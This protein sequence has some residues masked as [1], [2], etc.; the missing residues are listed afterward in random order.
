VQLSG[1]GVSSYSQYYTLSTRSISVSA[2]A[3]AAVACVGSWGDWADCSAACGGGT[4]ARSYT[5]T[6]QDSNGG[7]ACPSDTPQS[8][9]CNADACA[10]DA[11]ACVG[12]WGD[13]ADCSA[14]CGGGTEARSYTVTRQDSNGGT[15]CPSDTPQSQSCNVAACQV[16]DIDCEITF[17]GDVG[18]IPPGSLARDTFEADFKNEM[19]STL[20]VEP[21]TI[22]VA[23]IVGGSIVVSFTVEVRALSQQG[24]TAQAV[25][26]ALRALK[27]SD[28]VLTVGAFTADPATMVDARAR[29][30][31]VSRWSS[32]QLDHICHLRCRGSV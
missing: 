7:T 6:R 2:P 28:A 8:R 5:V 30:C 1:T 18:A 25:T 4:E 12:S 24:D 23:R 15:A 21:G 14:A 31:L 32:D 3:A 9:A 27:E 19:G 20:G 16:V 11:V 26:L 22:T 29:S 13:W 17:G 10:P